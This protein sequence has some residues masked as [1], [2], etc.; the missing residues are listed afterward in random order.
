MWNSNPLQFGK[1]NLRTVRLLRNGVPIVQ[2][3]TQD[4]TQVYYKT[5]QSLLFDRDGPEITLDNYAN[6]FYL[7]FDL[8]STQQCNHDVYYPEIVGA[9]ICLELEFSQPTANP[10]EVFVVGERL[11][12]ITIDH[13]G[14]VQK[15]G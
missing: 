11:S 13:K 4:N 15:H 8:T 3:N 10:L 14:K 6:H 1:H 9:P 7:V 12:T 2:Y 5:L